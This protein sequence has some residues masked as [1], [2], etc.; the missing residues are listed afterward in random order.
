VREIVPVR[1]RGASF[2]FF[3]CALAVIEIGARDNGLLR[4]FLPAAFMDFLQAAS[5]APHRLS[6]DIEGSNRTQVFQ[7]K[8]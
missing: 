5:F 1:S 6:S 7:T 8:T 2:G 4:H 3:G